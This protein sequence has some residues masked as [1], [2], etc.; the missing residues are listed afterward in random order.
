MDTWTLRVYWL[1]IQ[2]IMMHGILDDSY[3]DK[4]QFSVRDYRN[5]MVNMKVYDVGVEADGVTRLE[6]PEEFKNLD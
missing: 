4:K 5:L 2:F 6:E 1:L 3:S